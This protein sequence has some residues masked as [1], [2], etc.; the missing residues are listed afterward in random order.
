MWKERDVKGFCKALFNIDITVLQA[1]IIR[2]ITFSEHKRVVICCMTRYGKS[3]AVSMGILLW[4]LRNDN[5]RIAIIAPTNEKSSIIRNYL[6]FF[7]AKSP[8]F[9]ELLDLDK[10]GSERIRKEVSKQRMTWKNGVEMRTLSAEGKGAALMGFGADLVIVDETCDIDYEVY[11]SKISRMLGDDPEKAAYVE[12]GNPWHR[13][14]HMWIHWIN[15]GWKHIHI[16]YVDAEKDGR[17]SHDFIEEQR[18]QLTERE[19][20]VLYEAE[21]P[22]ETEDQLIKWSWIQNSI[23]KDMPVNDFEVVA[24]ADIAE[25]GNDST[26]LTIGFKN[27]LENTFKVSFI[28][29]WEQKETMTTAGMIA[30]HLKAHNVNRVTVDSNGIGAGVYSRLNELRREGKINTIIKDYRGGKQPSTKA[31][32]NRFLNQKAEA[33]FNLR[34]LFEKGKI[35]IIKEPTLIDQLSKMKWEL[36][37][38]MKIRIRDPGT[39]EGDTAEEKSPDYADSLCYMCWEGGT[40]SMVLGNLTDGLMRKEVLK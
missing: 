40:P 37:S 1:D 39:M 7:V 36:N 2:T 5:K 27:K 10:G 32:Q 24:G 9:T 14:N 19:F 31:A 30:E 21:F 23:K 33:Y 15:P 17:I 12:I 11:R 38:S 13:D 25:H 3:Y 8:Y 6:S 34:D 26:V 20:K 22:E 18:N 4:I 28:Y 35:S 16:G 29:H